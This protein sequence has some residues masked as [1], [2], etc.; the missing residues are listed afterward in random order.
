MKA[1]IEYKIL[2]LVNKALRYNEPTYLKTHL[3]KLR[4]N[5]NVTVRHMS[6]EHRLFEP[7]TNSKLGEITFKYSAPRLY[8]NLPSE[9][10]NIQ[11]EEVYKRKLKTLLF[12][13]SY[14]TED[15]TIQARYKI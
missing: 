1:R 5:T 12:G 4:L 13:R 7:R 15:L 11:E 3:N 8:N 14:D 10:K 9:M 2:L 6:D